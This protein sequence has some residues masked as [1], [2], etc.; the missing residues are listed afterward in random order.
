[1][2]LVKSLYSG[3]PDMI[4]IHMTVGAIRV[5]SYKSEKRQHF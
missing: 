5:K 2:T 4:M 3:D 1:M